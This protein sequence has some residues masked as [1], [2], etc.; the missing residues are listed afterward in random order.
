[1]GPCQGR[2]CGPAVEFLTGWHAES[3]RPPVYP[4]RVQDLCEP[5]R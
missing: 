4:A 5:G 1:M 3:V 2:V